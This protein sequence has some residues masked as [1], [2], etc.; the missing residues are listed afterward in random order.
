[1]FFVLWTSVISLILVEVAMR[2]VQGWYFEAP[3]LAEYDEVLGFVP[4]PN[5]S[6]SIGIGEHRFRIT[7][8]SL[9]LRGPEVR[10]DDPAL[11]VFLLG[12]SYTYGIGTD[13]SGTI[14]RQLEDKL[15]A[16]GIDAEVIN[17]GYGGYSTAQAYS[18]FQRFSYL[19]P[20]AVVYIFCDN[21]PLD[22]GEYLAKKR[23][24]ESPQS[25]RAWWR[26][27]LRRHSLLWNGFKRK[28]FFL[29]QVRMKNMEEALPGNFMADSTIA[30]RPDLI[31]LTLSYADSIAILAESFG[32]DYY[33]GFINVIFE[34]TTGVKL[35]PISQAYRN[36]FVEHG[37]RTL[38]APDELIAYRHNYYTLLG[39][40]PFMGHFNHVFYELFAEE[41][42]KTLQK[43]LHSSDG[44]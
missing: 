42:F 21:D 27:A 37:Y 33:I 28:Q 18:F 23:I 35:G 22:T 32:A 8:N 44:Y 5:H 10:K 4:R 39:D 41:I 2:A 40:V 24:P 7:Q 20:D 9:G 11:R 12:D 17:L 16:Q 25:Y 19:E 43:E 1:M 26:V 30:F 15:R 13:D 14:S 29:N 34:D 3:D 6:Q 38:N 36:H 31:Q